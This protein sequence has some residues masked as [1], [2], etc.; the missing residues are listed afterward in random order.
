LPAGSARRITLELTGADVGSGELVATAFA[1]ADV[2]PANDS[3]AAE[4]RVEPAPPSGTPS[5]ATAPPASSGSGG[6]GASE[7]VW[8]LLLA[9]GAAC[10]T[11][12]RAR[13]CGGL[14]ASAGAAR[15]N[16]PL[17]RDPWRDRESA[18]GRR[19]AQPLDD[20]G[21]RPGSSVGRAAD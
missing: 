9:F 12:R 20:L 4:F 13:L 10:L 5:P 17:A 11:H 7:P 19:T 6:G 2:D 8:L 3:L 1:D 18:A 14:V 15:C 21:K 16:S